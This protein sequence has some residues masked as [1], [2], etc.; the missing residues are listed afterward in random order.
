MQS[1]PAPRRS[2]PGREEEIDQPYRYKE[3]LGATLTVLVRE[4]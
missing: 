3:M 2:G 1:N 4:D